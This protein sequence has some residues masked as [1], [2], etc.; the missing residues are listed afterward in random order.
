MFEESK[1]NIKIWLMWKLTGWPF[2]MRCPQCGGT[3]KYSTETMA[4]YGD[5]PYVCDMC[6]GKGKVKR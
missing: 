5:E 4:R 2:K 1:C 6:K 3:G